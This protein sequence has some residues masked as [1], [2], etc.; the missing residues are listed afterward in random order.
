MLAFIAAAIILIGNKEII[1]YVER[2]YDRE[3]KPF[4]RQKA[5]M[6]TMFAVGVLILKGLFL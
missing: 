3:G 2:K 1:N 5:F 4:D 6:L